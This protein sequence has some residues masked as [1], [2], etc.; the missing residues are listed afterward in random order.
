MFYVLLGASAALISS[1][2]SSGARS[3]APY[4]VWTEDVHAMAS[5]ASVSQ[6]LLDYSWHTTKEPAGPILYS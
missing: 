5:V 1:F 2:L 6:T 3:A 4:G